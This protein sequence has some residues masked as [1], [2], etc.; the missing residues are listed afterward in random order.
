MKEIIWD[1]PLKKHRCYTISKLFQ[2]SLL[3]IKYC[4]IPKNLVFKSRYLLKENLK[5]IKKQTSRIV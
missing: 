2:L 3:F 1:G 5:Y 4:E